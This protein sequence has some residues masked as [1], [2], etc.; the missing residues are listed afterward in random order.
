M[1]Q[2]R[3]PRQ[4]APSE[5]GDGTL[6]GVFHSRT[7]RPQMTKGLSHK[8]MRLQG[9]LSLVGTVRGW[10]PAGLEMRHTASLGQTMNLSPCGKQLRAEV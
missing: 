9:V 2:L 8:D 3:G 6:V 4:H 1:S 7:A 5:P 10:R